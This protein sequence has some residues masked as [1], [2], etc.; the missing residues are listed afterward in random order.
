MR[1]SK[2]R[3]LR[4]M[5]KLWWLGVLVVAIAF[6]GS[7][8]VAEPL[9]REQVPEPLRP[10][11]DWVLRGHEGDTCPFFENAGDR[12]QCAWPSRLSLDLDENS[13]RLTQQWRIYRDAWVPLPGDATRWPQDVRVDG[14][15]AAATLH[16]NL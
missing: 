6:H 15:P 10:W 3:M 4:K 11:V 12:R 9:P 7:A 8:A 5:R 2:T 14:K 13:G 1:M 16:D